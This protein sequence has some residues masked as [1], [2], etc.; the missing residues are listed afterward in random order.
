MS[1]S[2][3]GSDSGSGRDSLLVV[4]VLQRLFCVAWLVVFGVRALKL[5]L[6][7]V[8]CLCVFCS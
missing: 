5:C 4:N 3:S 1:G 6:L 2:C 7:H 8:F